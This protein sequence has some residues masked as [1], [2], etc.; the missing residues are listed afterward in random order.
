VREGD[1]HTGEKKNGGGVQ[2]KLRGIVNSE[3]AR[4]EESLKQERRRE[5][6]WGV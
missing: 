4:G 5:M 3:E 2:K 1:F 6:R